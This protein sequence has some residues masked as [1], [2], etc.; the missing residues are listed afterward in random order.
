MVSRLWDTASKSVFGT[1]G[2]GTSSSSSSTMAQEAKESTAG[3]QPP[4]ASANTS[5]SS[6]FNFSSPYWDSSTYWNYAN[7]SLNYASEKTYLT[8][9][10]IVSPFYAGDSLFGSSTTASSSTQSTDPSHLQGG[11]SPRPFLLRMADRSQARMRQHSQQNQQIPFNTSTAPRVSWNILTKN[12]YH[13]VRG[14]HSVSDRRQSLAAVRSFLALVPLDE[15]DEE[16]ADGEEDTTNAGAYQF[17]AAT[18][19][20]LSPINQPPRAH[21]RTA[22]FLSH[23]SHGNHNQQRRAGRD[24]TASQV[25]EGTLRAL[26]DLSLEEAVELNTAL[27]FWSSR[28]ERPLLSWLEAG[29]VV[30]TSPVGYR[31]RL[32]GERVAQLQAVIARRCAA[33]GQLQEHLLRAGWQQGVAQWGVLDQ[34]QTVSGVDGSI[35]PDHDLLDSNPPSGLSSSHSQP[36]ADPKPPMT[37]AHPS[38]QSMSESQRSIT[39]RNISNQGG[40]RRSSSHVGDSK[41][42]DTSAHVLVNKGDG[43]GLYTDHPDFIAEWAV[44][45]IALVRRHLYRAANGAIELPYEGN[46]SSASDTEKETVLPTWV[47]RV[48]RRPVSSMDEEE[49]PVGEEA[50]TPLRVSDLNLMMSEV[51]AL[52]N[53]ME[54]VMLLQRKRRLDRLRA[55]SWLRRNW[56]IAVTVGPVAGWIFY[57]GFTKSVV[58]RAFAHIRNFIKERLTEPLTA[59]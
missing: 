54:G 19:D 23:H 21:Q 24:V 3:A 34:F 58:S 57:K 46:W 27:R 20:M 41:R 31:H 22:S 25:A 10:S 11:S 29:P 35:R 49:E 56:Y 1:S 37:T 6:Y 59:M 28:W 39:S 2:G 32:I 8:L 48:N 16:N 15:E 40:L 45:A 12:P 51:S 55:P 47:T 26:R 42:E 43:E 5:S 30:W 7:R 52:V 33:I 17:D 36:S 14:R 44:Q 50:S 18:D 38:Q 9:A 4:A 53:V 13:S